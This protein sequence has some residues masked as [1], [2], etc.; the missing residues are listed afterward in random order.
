MKRILLINLLLLVT[1]IT[2]AV[3]EERW[4][5]QEQVIRGNAVFQ[6][7]CA[8][9]HGSNAEATSDW[10]KTDAN[11]KYPP[12][13]LNGTA[14]TWHHALELLRSTIRKGGAQVGGVMPAFKDTLSDKEI[15]QAIAFFQSKWPDEIYD[16]WAGRFLDASVPT[17]AEPAGDPQSD[18]TQYLRQLLNGV[19]PGAPKLTAIEGVWQVKLNNS[20]IYLLEDGQYAVVGDLINLKNGQ[21]V[22]QLERSSTARELIN[23]YGDQQLVVYEP[24]GKTKATLN[25]FTDTSCP[26]CRKL[27]AELPR[28]L[29]AGIRVRYLPYARGGKSGPGYQT[30]R[31][32][33]CAS[34]RNKALTDAKKDITA[35]LPPGDCP[36][37]NVVD[38]GYQTGNEI[39]VTGTPA[40][41]K[42]TGEKIPGG[43]VPYQQLI[44]MLVGE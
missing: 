41:Y 6:Q 43:Y 42:E 25:V 36:L 12:P 30:M 2:S 3:A 22:T 13:P 23:D 39:G 8:S 29:E 18:V 26:Y 1:G 14:H 34:D 28:L 37:A 9:C 17:I 44:P 32:V 35:G 20:Y 5:T 40:L 38:R 10:R 15:D 24:Q 11:G 7:N 31:S 16:R 27:H 33:W 21:N 4:Y 19:K